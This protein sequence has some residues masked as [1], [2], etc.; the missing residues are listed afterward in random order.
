MPSGVDLGPFRGISNGDVVY[1]HTIANQINAIS[2]TL[3]FNR[4][5]ITS[6]VFEIPLED[7]Q[8]Q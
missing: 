5:D 4:T 6:L 1:G 7:S 2:M 8:G 3:T